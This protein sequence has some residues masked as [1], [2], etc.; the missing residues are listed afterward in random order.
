MGPSGRTTHYQLDTVKLIYIMQF[1][2]KYLKI[3]QVIVISR[4]KHDNT[5]TTIIM[6]IIMLVIIII[7]EQ[8]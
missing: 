7:K 3:A 4:I 6:I 2:N 8:V 1:I 5:P